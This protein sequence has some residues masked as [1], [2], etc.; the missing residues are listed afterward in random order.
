[1]ELV[2][3]GEPP[4]TTEE[5]VK[6]DEQEQEEDEESSDAN[7]TEEPEQTESCVSFAYVSSFI[8]AAGLALLILKKRH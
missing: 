6:T 5:E 8:A 4:M 2:V 3:I 1:M 7:T